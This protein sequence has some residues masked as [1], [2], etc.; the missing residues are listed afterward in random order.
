VG[1]RPEFDVSERRVTV[2]VR[3]GSEALV[4]VAQ[5]LATTGVPVDDLALRHPTLD[6]VFLRLTSSPS[7]AASPLQAASPLEAAS[8]SEAVA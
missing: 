6:E 7:E 5:A 2:P 3:G 4:A 8:P 1:T